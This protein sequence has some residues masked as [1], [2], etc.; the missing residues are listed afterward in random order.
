MAQTPRGYRR[1][2]REV[3]VKK[4]SDYSES[5]KHSEFNSALARD[6]KTNDLSHS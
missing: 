1:E 4:N 3:F 5:Q 2:V 6:K